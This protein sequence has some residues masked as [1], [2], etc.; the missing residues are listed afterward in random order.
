MAREKKLELIDKQLNTYREQ[1]KEL[2]QKNQEYYKMQY[3]NLNWIKYAFITFKS[4]EAQEAVLKIFVEK[5]C[6]GLCLNRIKFNTDT[7]FCGAQ[8]DVTKTCDPE[9]I[10]WENLKTSWCQKF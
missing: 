2:L 10:E 4:I 7:Q 5:G 8:L 6:C 3:P 1:L 9:F